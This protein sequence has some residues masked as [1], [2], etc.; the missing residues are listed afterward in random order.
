M[1]HRFWV[2]L[3]VATLAQVASEYIPPGP[4]YQCPKIRAKLYPCECVQSG[5]RGV[6]IVCENT[7]LASLSVGLK[8]F[9]NENIPVEK[10]YLSKCNI[11]NAY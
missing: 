2:I 11:G 10:L 8:N 4:R 6:T 9:G 5:D 1:K 3:T 7:N